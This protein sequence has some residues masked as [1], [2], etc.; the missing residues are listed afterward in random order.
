[1]WAGGIF[2][3]N[4]NLER[5]SIS[6]FL[7]TASSTENQ[8]GMILDLIQFLVLV[9]QRTYLSPHHYDFRRQEV[10]TGCIFFGCIQLKDNMDHPDPVVG[11]G[12]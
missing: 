1:V 12:Y 6:Y 5:L 2:L 7:R 11:L 3:G 9:R 8:Q 4:W 10:W